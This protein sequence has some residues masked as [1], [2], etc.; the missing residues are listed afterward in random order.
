MTAATSI[1]EFRLGLPL[2]LASLAATFL[3]EKIFL[4]RFVDFDAAQTAQGLG[5]MLRV[6]QHWG[7]RLF[8]ALIAAV[9]LFAYVPGEG[10]SS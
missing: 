5:A 8:V 2:R 4:N 10:G 1:R 7:F 6:G 9:I 3:A